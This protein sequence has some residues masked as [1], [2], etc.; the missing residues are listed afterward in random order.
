MN[1]T[2]KCSAF[3]LV[4]LLVVIAIIGILIAL[5]LPAVQAAREAAR[6]MEC[7]DHM[8]NIA[9]AQHNHHDVYG[10]LPNSQC[11]ASMGYPILKKWD[12]TGADY[13]RYAR[14]IYSYLVPSLPYMEQASL[15]DTI[16][17]MIETNLNHVYVHTADNVDPNSF[18]LTTFIGP[19]VCPSDPN[20]T[21][22]R[23]ASSYLGKP[24]PGSY[25][26]CLG[27][28]FIKGSHYDT[29]RGAYRTGEYVANFSAITDGTSNTAMLGEVAIYN[30]LD[31]TQPVIGGVIQ[32]TAMVSSSNLSV[33]IAAGAARNGK[34]FAT[35][36]TSNII[37]YTMAGR[38]WANGIASASG[39]VT[40]MPPN[41][42]S[43][44]RYAVNTGPASC[45]VSSYHS[46]GVNIAMC[47]GAVRFVS[48][49]I[50]TGDP[51]VTLSGDFATAI[52][53][54]PWGVWGAMGS[55]DG[56]ENKSL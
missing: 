44:V 11:Q 56:G 14:S 33:C 55:R 35:A 28:Y 6:R 53:E 8:K 40:A 38:G 19:Y 46:G 23:D 48:E 41:S 52:G 45:T 20:T 54:S 39:F 12:G 21:C 7:T 30:V 2:L 26:C 5:L 27:D 49:T 13:P 36:F 43:C 42:P 25:H 50:N 51:G 29:P 16:K 31:S 10:Y 37:F 17:R 1:S 34:F 4:E 22:F 24:A 9:L 15:Y 3:T 18:P 32:A 47:D